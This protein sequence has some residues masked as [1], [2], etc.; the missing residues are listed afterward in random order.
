MSDQISVASHDSM[1]AGMVVVISGPGGVGK[2]T[3]S[4]LVAAVFDLS[5]HIDAVTSWLRSSAV[6][7]TRT[8]QKQISRTTRL[9]ERLP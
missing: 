7:S 4:K 1:P 9:A 6:G 5:V 2:T 8:C 3:V